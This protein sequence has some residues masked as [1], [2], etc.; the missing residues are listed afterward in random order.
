[1]SQLSR[2]GR[3]DGAALHPIDVVREILEQAG[4]LAR[5]MEIHYLVQEPGLLDI[6]R[7]LG[8]LSNGERVRLNEFLIARKGYRLELRQ[9]MANT[10]ALEWTAER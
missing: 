8:A 5:L 7:A 6:M 1:M 2:E 3:T 10:L 9:T 4:S